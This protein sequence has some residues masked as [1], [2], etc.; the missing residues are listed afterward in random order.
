MGLKVGNSVGLSVGS[1]PSSLGERVGLSVGFIVGLLMSTQFMF[2]VLGV[3]S[4][5]ATTLEAMATKTN[6]KCSII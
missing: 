4:L 5:A 1:P 2:L 3:A 6:F